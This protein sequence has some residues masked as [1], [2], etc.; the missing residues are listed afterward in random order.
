M[1]ENKWEIEV[2]CKGVAKR[3]RKVKRHVSEVIATAHDDGTDASRPMLGGHDLQVM[4]RNWLGKWMR[5]V[6]SAV[7]R[8]MPVEHEGS[9]KRVMLF[10][11]RTFEHK[12]EL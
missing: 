9:I 7:I 12:V 6:E 1:K 8:A 2:I 3:E 10:N 4:A 11:P 5:T